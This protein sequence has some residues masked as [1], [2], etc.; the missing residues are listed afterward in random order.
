MSESELIERRAA[1]VLVVDA[2]GRVLMLRGCDPAD[3]A[4]RY[5]FTVGGGMEPHESLA[6]AAVR[7]LAE[8]T[9]LRLG[10]ADLG[11]PV[12]NDVA[13]FPFDGRRYRQEQ[14][15]FLVRVPTWEVDRSGFD[16]I[17]RATVDEVSWWTRDD[18]AAA[19]EP[20]YPPDLP[21][22]LRRV[23]VV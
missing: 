10:V 3:P 2:A 4:V 6:E 11:E 23:G 15:W 7:E 19:T 18:F 13:E 20:Y 8:E 22:L 17:E 5:W 9:G 1:R 16:E 14:S 12:W 21:A